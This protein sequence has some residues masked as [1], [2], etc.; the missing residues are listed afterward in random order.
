MNHPSQN[1][2]ILGIETS[3]TTGG[4]ALLADDRLLASLS[5]AS[6]TLYSQRLLPSI[7]W[8]LEKTK[9]GIG[10][11][12]GVAVSRGPGSFTGLR[13]GMSAAKAIAYANSAPIVAVS[14]LEALALRGASC[15]FTAA[16]P[17]CPMLDA[18]QG[19]IYAALFRA[20]R[21]KSDPEPSHRNN[22]PSMH[23]PERLTEDYAGK[24]DDWAKTI[25]EP[26]LFLGEG[27]LRYQAELAV[28]LGNK[29][30]LAPSIRILPSAEEIA[31]LGAW[32]IM[33][34]EAD[35]AASLEPDYH[36][37]S[38]QDP[39]TNNQQTGRR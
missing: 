31:W 13:I 35:D 30:I 6:P 32:R 36:R 17:L 8:L 33:R 22:A 24:L 9:T 29:F 27:A 16:M 28:L 1:C 7:E 37:H 26:A 11:I 14:T 5:F 3:G 38:W 15:A 18:R 10:E 19:E 4:A 12:T 2:I 34:G 20:A 39:R 21:E 23:P 25:H